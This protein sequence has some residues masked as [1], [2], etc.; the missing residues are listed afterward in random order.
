ML[1]SLLEEWGDRLE[2][3]DGSIP[4]LAADVLFNQ[5][6]ANVEVS[7]A[8]TGDSI[9]SSDYP[10]ARQD[11]G[12]LFIGCHRNGNEGAFLAALIGRV[13]DKDMAIMTKPYGL[14]AKGLA[15]LA[16]RQTN[17]RARDRV[18]DALIS[19]VPS[20]IA[21][22]RTVAP[23]QSLDRWYWRAGMQHRLP[24]AS[25]IQNNNERANHKMADY[26]ARGDAGL[27]FPTGHIGDAIHGIW[28]HGVARAMLVLPE[29]A[30]SE[31]DIVFFRFA[32]YD[33][34]QMACAVMRGRPL[35]E[36]TVRLDIAPVITVQ[37]VLHSHDLGDPRVAEAIT[38][39]MQQH[40]AHIF[41][42]G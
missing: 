39:D 15:T 6:G 12:T 29:V 21:R 25:E 19:V 34:T 4:Q 28:R 17:E 23:H 1:G 22:E 13:P 11:R 41:A 8:L 3:L 31:T 26:L 33:K 42:P 36:H 40:Y 7:E 38:K 9:K 14:L 32:G 2:K 35:V 24:W 20:R 30:R 5:K 16:A 18:L 10:W 37:D 27:I